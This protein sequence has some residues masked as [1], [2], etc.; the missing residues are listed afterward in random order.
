MTKKYTTKEI[1]KLKGEEGLVAV[2]CGGDITDWVEGLNEIVYLCGATELESYW[3]IDD[4][5]EFELANITCIYF[6]IEDNMDMGKL[7]VIRIEYMEWLKWLSDFQVNFA[8]K[9]E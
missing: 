9:L 3:K 4:V 6:P 8:D 2:G 7:A 5:H 1:F